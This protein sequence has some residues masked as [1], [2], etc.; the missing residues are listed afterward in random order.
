MPSPGNIDVIQILQF[1]PVLG[2]LDYICVPRSRYKYDVQIN[3]ARSDESKSTSN[4]TYVPALDCSSLTDKR[5]YSSYPGH[6]LG[7]Y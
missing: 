2:L 1:A 5:D 3:N 7:V 4:V 6:L